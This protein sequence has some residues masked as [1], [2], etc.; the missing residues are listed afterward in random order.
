MWDCPKC[1]TKVDSDFEICWKCGTT[2]EG[3]EDP[4]FQVADE[5]PPILDPRYDPIA[6]PDPSIKVKQD[7]V[8]G[9]PEDELVP[10]YQAGS[11][12]EAKFLADQLVEQGIPAV[13]DTSD[14]QD[15][16]GT[17]DGNPR[18]YCRAHDLERARAWLSE[19]NEAQIRRSQS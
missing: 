9:A 18:V 16:F 6:T 14:F 8:H 12:P 5:V 17:W 2:R 1:G 4:E 10:C 3:V 7:S 13:S 19:Y 11:L 15:A